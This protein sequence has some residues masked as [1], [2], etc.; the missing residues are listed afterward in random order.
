MSMFFFLDHQVQPLFWGPPQAVCRLFFGT[1]F[2]NVPVSQARV[3]GQSPALGRSLFFGGHHRPHVASFSGQYSATFRCLRPGSGGRVPL[4][5]AASFLGV[6]H[7]RNT[8]ALKGAAGTGNCR[9]RAGRNPARFLCRFLSGGSETRLKESRCESFPPLRGKEKTSG[10][11]A[12]PFPLLPAGECTLFPFSRR[13]GERC[14]FR[15]AAVRPEA[16]LPQED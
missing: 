9:L 13:A 5:G 4:W 7:R 14:F 15:T 11:S 1:A 3:R 6:N 2:G 8:D 10:Y 16:D 12:V